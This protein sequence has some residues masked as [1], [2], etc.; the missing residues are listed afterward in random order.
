MPPASHFAMPV[1]D[2]KPWPAIFGISNHYSIT[3]LNIGL[4]TPFAF[5]CPHNG[6]LHKADNV[7]CLIFLLTG[8]VPVPPNAVHLAVHV[9]SFSPQLSEFV[10]S[11]QRPMMFAVLVVY[12][13]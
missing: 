5:G 3:I 12:F 10:P 7:G 8:F 4:G 13:R 9:S 1:S 11:N 6:G 2:A